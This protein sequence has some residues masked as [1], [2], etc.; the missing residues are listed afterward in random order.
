MTRHIFVDNSNIFRGAQDASREL[1]PTLVWQA[2]RVYYRNFLRLIEKSSGDEEIGVR[3]LAGSVPPDNEEL[4]GHAESCGYT[5]DLL[6]RVESDDGRMVEQSV[7]ETLHLKIAN[8]ILDHAPQDAPQ[9]LVIASGDGKDTPTGTS[10]PG[11]AERA[12]KHGWSVEIWSWSV[13]LSN[14]FHVL[15]EAHPEKMVVEVLDPFYKSITFLKGGTYSI[16]RDMEV[17]DRIVSP[18]PD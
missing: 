7:D 11:Q 18:L 3:V 15:A 12:L 13:S 9:T 4:W 10:F 14:R 17:A 2:V 16:T 6:Q 1:E 5:T 8:T